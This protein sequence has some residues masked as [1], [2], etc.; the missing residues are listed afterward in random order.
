MNS[1]P[2]GHSP[3][4]GELPKELTTI[5][6]VGL[7]YCG[8]TLINN[9]LSGLPDCIGVGETHWIIDCEDDPNQNGKC[10]ECFKEPCPVFNDATLAKLKNDIT[11]ENNKWWN[12]LGK[13]SECKFVISGDKRPFHYDRFGIPD[14]LLF[15]LK[16]PRAHIVSWAKRNFMEAGQN[17]D[18]YNK[19]EDKFQLDGE[20]FERALFVWLRDTRKHIS[21]CLETK[22]ELAVVSLEYFVEND[23]QVL[24]DIA[25]WIGTEFDAKAL[26]YWDT[27][28]HYI[29]SNHS[30]KRLNKD[31]YFFKQVKRDRRWE[32]VLTKEQSDFIIGHEKVQYQLNRLKPFVLGSQV[33]VDFD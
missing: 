15:L 25:E 13:S 11:I 18:S 6:I 32:N 1:H 30:V 14:K 5:G 4:E 17:L 29:G 23:E 2:P 27:D 22:K 16:D 28:L 20:Q 7:D 12:E 9:I 26:E 31:R 3:E 21:W 19:G 33:L 10:T 8:S 24:K